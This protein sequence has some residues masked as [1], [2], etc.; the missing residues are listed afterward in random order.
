[1]FANSPKEHSHVVPIMSGAKW[2]KYATKL[3]MGVQMKYDQLANDSCESGRGT[4]RGKLPASENVQMENWI[5]VWNSSSSS[6][7]NPL[8]ADLHF[9]IEMWNE[10][11]MHA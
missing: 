4:D 11:E 7:V 2:Q 9:V 5:T 1:M 8:S 6:I 3:F 10:T